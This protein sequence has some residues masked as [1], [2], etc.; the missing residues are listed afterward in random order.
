MREHT[1]KEKILKIVNT[2]ENLYLSR[3]LY[4]LETKSMKIYN[5]Y[6]EIQIMYDFI[7]KI[8]EKNNL[9]VRDN[10]RDLYENSISREQA[11]SDLHN[12]FWVRTDMANVQFNNY[13]RLH[14]ILKGLLDCV[15][16]DLTLNRNFYN[17]TYL[18]SKGEQFL[19]E[20]LGGD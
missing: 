14:I 11:E 2:I 1:E 19:H 15:D 10:V 17:N 5:T 16:D 13:V 6:N 8:A 9:I 4:K 7:N 18:A 20:K 3:Y 12:L